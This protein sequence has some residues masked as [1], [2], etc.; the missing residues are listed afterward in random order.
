MTRGTTVNSTKDRRTGQERLSTVVRLRSHRRKALKE[1]Y[2]VQREL[3]RRKA[4]K[5]SYQ[6]QRELLDG[7]RGS[8]SVRRGSN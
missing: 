4:L 6:V 5:E 8:G 1:G 3:H 7:A 2:Q